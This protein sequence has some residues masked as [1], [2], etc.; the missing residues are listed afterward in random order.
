LKDVNGKYLPINL[1]AANRQFLKNDFM[2]SLLSDD[3]LQHYGAFF[4]FEFS[5]YM[6]QVD[7]WELNRYLL[8][9]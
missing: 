7:E 2:R 8:N 9:I 4:N 6:N 3:I 5:E 1:N